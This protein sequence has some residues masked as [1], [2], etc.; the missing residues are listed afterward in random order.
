MWV[1][2]SAEDFSCGPG[3]VHLS[4]ISRGFIHH[5]MFTV[6]MKSLSCDLYNGRSEDE[7]SEKWKYKKE[8][9]VLSALSARLIF[10]D[11]G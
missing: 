8:G 9:H 3:L 2:I 11:D 7:F 1:F 6:A 5:S 10:D 4:K